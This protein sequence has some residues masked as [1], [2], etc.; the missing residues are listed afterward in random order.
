MPLRIKSSVFMK[1]LYA[2][3][4]ASQWMIE[5]CIRDR[6]DTVVFQGKIPRLRAYGING[7]VQQVPLAGGNLPH[8]IPGAAGIIPVSYTHLDVYKRQLG[9]RLFFGNFCTLHLFHFKIKAFFCKVYI[10]HTVAGLDFLL[11]E[12]LAPAI[13]KLALEII[14]QI[15]HFRSGERFL[16]TNR[17]AA[18]KPVSYTHLDVYKRQVQ[19]TA[20]R[21]KSLSV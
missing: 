4:R 19:P 8:G 15:P 21:N 17:G 7:F 2:F 9:N 10:Q 16:Q 13:G 14:L 11:L 18:L 6:R 20:D 1:S 5:M 12:A 3:A